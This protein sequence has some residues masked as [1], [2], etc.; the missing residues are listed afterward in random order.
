MQNGVSLPQ[1][2]SRVNTGRRD[3]FICLF[4]AGW[5]SQALAFSL[6]NVVWQNLVI[7]LLCK[8]TLHSDSSSICAKSMILR[9]LS[10]LQDGVIGGL[11]SDHSPSPCADKLLDEGNFLKAWGGIS[12]IH[13]LTL[14][15]RSCTCPFI[16]FFLPSCIRS[17]TSCF[18]PLVTYSYT[19]TLVG[20]FVRLSVDLFI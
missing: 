15:C 11:A 18:I 12:G 6:F 17:F 3:L 14:L 8:T 10:S 19:F 5:G 9:V 1:A 7:S 2:F 4:F 20:S 16:H 13:H